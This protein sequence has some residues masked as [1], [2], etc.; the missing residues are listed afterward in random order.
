MIAEL[1]GNAAQDEQPQ[2]DHQRQVKSAEAGRVKRGK[3]KVQRAAR[4]E[5]PDFVAIPNGADGA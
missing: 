2:Y 3:G 1:D 5:Q 4:R